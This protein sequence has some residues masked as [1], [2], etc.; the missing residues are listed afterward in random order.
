MATFR[1]T[2]HMLALLLPTLLAGCAYD[3]AL[4]NQTAH[5][6]DASSIKLIDGQAQAPD[7]SQMQDAAY[8]NNGWLQ[9][10]N[11]PS[12]AFGCATYTNLARMLVNPQD[13]SAP[14]HYPGQ[15][16]NTAGS[17]VQRYYDNKVKKYDGTS[18]STSGGTSGSGGATQ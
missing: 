1:L 7:C 18:S 4:V 10:T 2:T 12:F 3:N 15:N 14:R 11:R 5:M 8:L 16:A 17:A 6:P 13:L 9:N